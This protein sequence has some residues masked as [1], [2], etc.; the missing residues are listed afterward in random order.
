MFCKK[1]EL[2][3]EDFN[4]AVRIYGDF[5]VF[6]LRTT[7][8]DLDNLIDKIKKEHGVGVDVARCKDV[9]TD[10]DVFKKYIDNYEI[11]I[12]IDGVIDDSGSIDE[13]FINVSV[14]LFQ[15]WM[16]GTKP[17]VGGEKISYFINEIYRVGE[18]DEDICQKIAE[19]KVLLTPIF[20]CFNCQSNRKDHHEVAV[21]LMIAS[22][23][24]DSSNLN[25]F[26]SCHEER[27]MDYSESSTIDLMDKILMELT[28]SSYVINS[29]F[30]I[31]RKKKM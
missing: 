14:H 4:E 23:L 2:R 16:I 29:D 19:I 15:S 26:I 13:N 17:L 25:R 7:G 6:Y 21:Y 22:R 10:Y 27:K 28:S 8:V 11:V 1:N 9:Y 24:R 12:Y 20:K 31:I 30:K 5:K 3:R 18:R